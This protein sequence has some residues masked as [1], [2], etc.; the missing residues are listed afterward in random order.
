MTLM[1]QNILC[2]FSLRKK[3]ENV[4]MNIE[5]SKMAV[6][7]LIWTHIL[8]CDKYEWRVCTSCSYYIYSDQY[9]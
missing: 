2:V 9:T 8:Q 3:G 7:T 6:K 4:N 1:C 5:K